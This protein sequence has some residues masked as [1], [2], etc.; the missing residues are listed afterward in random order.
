MGVIDNMRKISNARKNKNAVGRIARTAV[1]QGAIE[2][3]FLAEYNSF[4]V[5]LKEVLERT[6]IMENNKSLTIKANTSGT[7]TE[8]MENS[9]YLNYV[10]QDEEYLTLYEMERDLS[11]AI[12]FKLKILSYEED[13]EENSGIDLDYKREMDYFLK[14]N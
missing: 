2:N 7:S 12:T 10:L 6:L 4:S 9:R 1:Q 8:S 13:A 3:E 14:N 11:G 5:A